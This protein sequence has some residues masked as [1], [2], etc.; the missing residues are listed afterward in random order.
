MSFFAIMYMA[1]TRKLYF[2]AI[3]YTEGESGNAQLL[4]LHTNFSIV[5]KE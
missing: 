1:V 4:V 2:F 5:C 3:F